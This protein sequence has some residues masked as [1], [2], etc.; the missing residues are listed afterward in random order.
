MDEQITD[1]TPW[2]FH[3][4]ETGS[5]EETFALEPDS[6][7]ELP[8]P[9]ASFQNLSQWTVSVASSDPDD[10]EAVRDAPELTRTNY[11][12]VRRVGHGGCGEVWEAIQNNL[13]REIAVKLPFGGADAEATT[14]GTCSRDV[15]LGFRREALTTGNLEHPNI[16][17]VHDLGRDEQGRPLLAMKLV[18]GTPWNKMIWSD[19][20]LPLA[21]FLARH[22][23]ILIDVAQAVAFA[24]SKGIVHRD[25]K[26]SQ[27][28]VGRYGEVVLMDWGLALVFDEELAGH[29]VPL[30]V[31]SGL[32]PTKQ[33]AGGPAGTPAYMAPEQTQKH[34]LDVGPWTDVY[35][36]GGILYYLLAGRPP[37]DGSQASE[38]FEA[39]CQGRIHPLKG[40]TEGELIPDELRGLCAHAMAADPKDR[41]ES[42]E[43]FLGAIQ[44]YVTGAGRRRESQELTNRVEEE[45]AEEQLSPE[46]LDYQRLIQFRLQVG[47]AIQLWPENFHARQ[48]HESVVLLHAQKAV[49]GGDLLLAESM[50][51]SAPAG[52]QRER[53]LSKLEA[54]RAQLQRESRQRRLYLTASMVLV[55]MLLILGGWFSI[56]HDRQNRR[57][58]E[59]S[60]REQEN[61]RQ[62]ARE[63]AQR[64]YEAERAQYVSDIRFAQSRLTEGALDEAEGML[65][66]ID[67]SRR[68]IAWG[69]LM[70]L[71]HPELIALQGHTGAITGLDFSEDGHLLLSVGE[72]LKARI[73]DMDTGKEK[74]VFH[75]HRKRIRTGAISRDGKLAAT[76]GFTGSI[77][78]WETD[79]GRELY[80]WPVDART[81]EFA[82]DS[83]SFVAAGRDKYARVY[84]VGTGNFILLER[85][86]EEVANAHFSPNGKQI[87][88]ASYDNTAIVWDRE[89]GRVVV[90]LGE[91]ELGVSDALFSPSGGR[92]LTV[93]HDGQAGIWEANTGRLRMML[94]G[95]EGG[96]TACAWSPDGRRIATGSQ[97]RTVRIWDST[98]GFELVQ[99]QGHEEELSHVTFSPDGALIATTSLDRTVRVWQA[100]T[101]RQLAVLSRQ[102]VPFCP[103]RYSPRGTILASSGGDDAIQIWAPSGQ[104]EEFRLEGHEEE[105]LGLDFDPKGRFIATGSR[106]RTARLWDA[107][108]G[109]EFLDMDDQDR[110]VSSVAFFPDGERLAVATFDQ[111]AYVYDVRTGERLSTLKGHERELSTIDVAEG[112]IRILTCSFDGTARL[113]KANEEEPYAILEGHEGPVLVGCFND[114]GDLVVTGSS[115]QTARIWNANTGE[116][117][118]VLRGHNGSITA[119]AFGKSNK[120]LATG[121]SDNRIRLWDVQTGKPQ[122]WLVG[123]DGRILD[124]DFH[125]DGDYMVSTSDDGTFRLW[126]VTTG[127][128][129]V[130]LSDPYGAVTHARFSPSGRQLATANRVGSVRVWEPVPWRSQDLG[131]SPDLPWDERFSLWQHQRFLENIARLPD[132]RLP[133]SYWHAVY[134]AE[135]PVDIGKAA[136]SGAL[137]ALKEVSPR[138]PQVQKL[139][140]ETSEALATSSPETKI[141]DVA[142]PLLD[143]VRGALRDMQVGLLPQRETQQADAPA[144]KFDRFV[145]GARGP[146]PL[147]EQKAIPSGTPLRVLCFIRRDV[148]GH[149]VFIAGNLPELGSWEPCRVPFS[150]VEETPYG[151]LWEFR[152][153]Y[154]PMEFKL[155]YGREGDGWVAG[156]W[157]GIENR[158]IPSPTAQL[159]RL[160][161]GELL[162][163]TEFG[164]HPG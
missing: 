89:T 71:C 6:D 110:E 141:A 14:L 54:R 2:P 82:P 163:L 113:W 144:P 51:A 142:Q 24:H 46:T 96:L 99:L 94:N 136:F 65:L 73:W 122:Q 64:A 37:H 34:S 116:L 81:V 101:G 57:A 134:L 91:H 8:D 92:I 98:T 50:L 55:G 100:S 3:E 59:I 19:E 13:G 67:E 97:D 1:P 40:R 52:E 126:D 56:E 18:R 145:E 42:V 117:I 129:M 22:L 20:D 105:V 77:R 62:L 16:V 106:D 68:G 45:L 139:F 75:G 151:H 118:H 84:D 147:E 128:E 11:M 143:E 27:V 95:H 146:L 33:T 32:A 48:L 161:D 29:E 80:R 138:T 154:Q 5:P 160:P 132:R 79:T 164:K 69:L 47:R 93:S 149:K 157:W 7:E 76:C 150:H 119:A 121:S 4:P 78:L 115:D 39:A 153:P 25:L 38:A 131:G 135:Q 17:P 23:P 87:I 162:L 86:T 159:Y 127:R 85:H 88:T 124:L 35:L 49:E 156:E 90:V 26:P 31:K 107:G 114:D 103:P 130:R 133:A 140:V 137:A 152:L 72:D 74:Q 15:E 148:E 58:L 61:A 104:P 112:A 43:A 10:L 158:Q 12:L 30:L 28:M 108:N 41:I 102:A 63:A 83:L 21:D 123:H 120:R 70:R 125:P 9:D 53:L 111:S 60:M 36:L 66:G 44:D 155:C 109:R